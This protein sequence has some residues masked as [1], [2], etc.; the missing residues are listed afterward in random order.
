MKL[1]IRA[2]LLSALLICGLS[3]VT[4]S[5]AIAGDDTSGGGGDSG[6]TETST[7]DDGG[8]GGTGG[9]PGAPQ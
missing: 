1:R 4:A 8:T 3:V 9:S 7:G 5:G 6:T 2:A